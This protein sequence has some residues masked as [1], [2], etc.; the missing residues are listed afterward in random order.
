MWWRKQHFS[1]MALKTKEKEKRNHL[2]CS[3]CRW[4]LGYWPPPEMGNVKKRFSETAFKQETSTAVILKLLMILC[5]LIFDPGRHSS[6]SADCRKLGDQ[7]PEELC[8]LWRSPY[9]PLRLSI[10]TSSAWCI[11]PSFHHHLTSA[12]CMCVRLSLIA[13]HHISPSLS[14][15]LL[16]P[17]G[18]LQLANRIKF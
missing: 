12:V 2:V 8:R 3:K 1:V 5:W 11:V 7:T 16:S 10:F 15:S 18:W 9:T 14:L 6:C 13:S 17:L 4:K